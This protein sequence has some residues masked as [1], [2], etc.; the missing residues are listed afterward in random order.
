V[1][2]TPRR[3]DSDAEMLLA[4]DRWLRTPLSLLCRICT[5]SM[6]RRLVRSIGRRDSWLPDD[7][8]KRKLSIVSSL[9][10]NLPDESC[11][12]DER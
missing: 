9:A 4:D 11:S 6:N 3:V 5:A 7:R 8:F 1:S 10:Q 12:R 2:Y